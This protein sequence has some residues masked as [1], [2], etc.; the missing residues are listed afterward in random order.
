MSSPLSRLLEAGRR[1]V[2]RVSSSSDGGDV[3][4]P[5][6]RFNHDDDDDDDVCSTSSQ[7]SETSQDS[8][9]TSYDARLEL[10]RSDLQLFTTRASN[11]RR[12]TN[13]EA[14]RKRRRQMTRV[15]SLHDDDHDFDHAFKHR[16]KRLVCRLYSALVSESQIPFH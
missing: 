11:E 16:Q 1:Q 12:S 2:L 10:C 14:P 3:F 15:N 4:S 9:A 6:V 13:S 8:G 7:R 5:D